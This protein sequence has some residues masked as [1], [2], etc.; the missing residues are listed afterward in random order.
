MTELP[1]EAVRLQCPECASVEFI[2]ENAMP[3]CSLCGHR[4]T[5]E[6]MQQLAL[7]HVM[8]EAAR[9]TQH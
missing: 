2:V 6:D 3:V 9:S 8:K 7:E 1:P 4:I 5:P